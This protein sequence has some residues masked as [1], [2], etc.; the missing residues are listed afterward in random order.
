MPDRLALPSQL[1]DRRSVLRGLGL[2]GALLAVPGLTA[3]GGG[4][5]SG[6]SGGTASNSVTFGI[7]ANAAVPTE[8][9]DSVFEAFTDQSGIAVE[10]NRLLYTEQ[11]N[12][13]LTSAPDDLLIW[14]A[15]NRL[16]FFAE[17]GLVSDLTPVWDAVGG[18]FTD[19][20]KEAC[21][22]ADGQQYLM[23]FYNYPWVTYYRK[24]VFAERGYTVPTT[25]A[26]F[27]ALADQMQQDGLVPLAFADQ[28]GW[29]AMGTFDIINMRTNGYDFHIGLLNGEE[30]WE[31]ER[32]VETFQAWRDLLPYHQDG[33][34]GRGWQ[35]AAQELGQGSAGMYFIGSFAVDAFD[36][37]TQ[38]DLD[39]FPWPEMNPE[40]G[41]SA[42]DAPIDGFMMVADPDNEE[43]S[44]Q[45]LEFLAT[46]EA[47]ELYI[48]TDKNSVATAQDVDTSG[49]TALQTKYAEVI[50]ASS[51]IAQYLDRDTL[52]A[53]AGTVVIPAFQ[54]FLRAGGENIAEVTQSLQSQAASLFVD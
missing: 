8:G 19:A 15:G 32:V 22:A 27:T 39:F 37:A 34:L 51:N 26:D 31:D 1:V 18:N 16:R 13:Y 24:S 25:V 20:V 14:N 17:Q 38:E 30:S 52:P 42:I 48:Q 49:Y 7:N 2:G 12:N 3:C 40:H 4:G 29:E 21:T 28:E 10:T 44:T 5:G 6:G 53:F 45:L 36:E 11:I 33:P 41:Q 43:G 9:Y 23:P 35:E 46:K 50:A 47:A 54:D